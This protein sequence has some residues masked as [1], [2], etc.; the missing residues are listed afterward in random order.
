M[1]PYVRLPYWTKNYDLFYGNKRNFD[2]T[3]KVRYP[4]IVF[5]ECIKLLMQKKTC[6]VLQVKLTNLNLFSCKAEQYN[7]FKF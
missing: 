6:N 2:K 7:I 1:L 4:F 5:T 3:I